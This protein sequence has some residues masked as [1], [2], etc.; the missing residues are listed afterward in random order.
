[1]SSEAGSQFQKHAKDT[2]RLK[3]QE[4]EAKRSFVKKGKSLLKGSFPSSHV[5]MFEAGESHAALSEKALKTPLSVNA[6]PQGAFA[7]AN[8][9]VT[10]EGIREKLEDTAYEMQHYLE[11]EARSR[12]DLKKVQADLEKKEMVL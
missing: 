3:K 5:S 6:L 7:D 12:E 9:H 4:G 10:E 11:P 2:L 1:M 8:S